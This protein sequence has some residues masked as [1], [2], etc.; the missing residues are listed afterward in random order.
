MIRKDRRSCDIGGH[1]VP[2][3]D[4]NNK[5]VIVGSGPHAG[6]GVQKYA[7]Q[8]SNLFIKEYENAEHHH[9]CCNVWMNS[10]GIAE[11][12]KCD[13]FCLI[14]D[15]ENHLW[16]E[17]ITPVGNEGNNLQRFFFTENYLNWDKHKNY[18]KNV[19]LINLMRQLT[20]LNS[21]L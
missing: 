21:M 3:N 10:Q 20:Q 11:Y 7:C 12:A 13:L 16:Y 19:G 9:L 1:Q 17:S 2:Q 15:S 18:F 14:L 6:A 8:I 5:V 4:D